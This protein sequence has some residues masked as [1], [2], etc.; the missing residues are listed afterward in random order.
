MA[1]GRRWV[2]RDRYGNDIYLTQER[3]EHITGAISHPE[4]STSYMIFDPAG[5]VDLRHLNLS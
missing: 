5:R 3:W 4:M 1:T 2:V